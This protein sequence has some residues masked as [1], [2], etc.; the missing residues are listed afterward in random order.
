VAST[1]I[2]ISQ[3]A[4]EEARELARA[5]GK[6]ISQVVEAA[7]RAEHR[8]L[9]WASFRQAAATVARNPVASA[10]E[11]ADRELF[12]GTLADGLDA[13]TIPD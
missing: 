6:P 13:Q 10:A 7:I 12:E 5:T 1:T 2:R 11:A 8:R 4:R 3:K 9:F